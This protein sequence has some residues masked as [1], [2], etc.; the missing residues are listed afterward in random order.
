MIKDLE[1]KIG[2]L[3]YEISCL[4]L[5]QEELT[6]VTIR[7][8]ELK[9]LVKNIEVIRCCTELNPEFSIGE[10]VLLTKR[11]IVSIETFCEDGMIEIEDNNEYYKV[12]KE[13]LSKRV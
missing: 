3:Q 4:G 11:T 7:I 12:D 1:N 9:A 10:Q 5:D 8:E 2:Q 6:G 13:E